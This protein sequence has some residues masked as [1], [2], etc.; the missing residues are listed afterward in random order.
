MK[1]LGKA[2]FEQKRPSI[3]LFDAKS[4]LTD[5]NKFNWCNNEEIRV[6]SSTKNKEE[7]KQNNKVSVK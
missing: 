4:E 7:K 2:F 1:S 6:T 5:I 3:N